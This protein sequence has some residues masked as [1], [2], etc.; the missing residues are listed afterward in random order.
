MLGSAITWAEGS[1]KLEEKSIVIF[2]LFFFLGSV[3]KESL[4]GSLVFTLIPNKDRS[5]KDDKQI[6]TPYQQ[7]TP[8]T[9]QVETHRSNKF[10]TTTLTETS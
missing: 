7:K 2:F 4:S 3:S 6:Q 10:T 8:K 5:S 9:Q 1:E